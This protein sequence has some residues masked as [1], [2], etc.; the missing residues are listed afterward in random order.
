MHTTLLKKMLFIAL[1]VMGSQTMLAD[2]FETATEAVANMRVG[3]NLGNTLDS[4]SGDVN[5]MW[6]EKWSQR[7]PKDY[8]TAW[9]QPVTKPELMKLF[10]A[11]GFNAIR[12]PVT[13]YPHMEAKFLL[14]G[15]VWDM[16]NDDIGTKIQAAWMKRVHEVVDYVISQDM[17]C[18]LNIHHDTGASSTAWLIAS[19]ADYAKQKERYEEVWRQIAEEFKDYD[20]HL[21]FEGYNEMLDTYDS[22]CFA[23]FA[24]PNNYNSSVATSA[25]NA[26]NSYA[27]SFVD[28]V[29]AT[30]GNNAQ[31]NL[32]VSTYSASSGSGTWSSHLQDPLKKLKLPADNVKDH[33]IFEVHSYIDVK[34]LSSAKSEVK[35]T[36]S[37][38]KT[39]LKGAPVI[40]GEW[41]TS[42][43]NGYANY[44]SNMLAFAR[45]FVEQAKANNMG[46]FYWMGLSDGQHRS[47][48]EF[49]EADLKDAII[50]GY[51]GDEGY[52]GITH[53]EASP[54]QPDVY[55][56]LS[57]HRLPAPQR[58]LNIIREADGTVRKVYR[59]P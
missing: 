48:P 10:K 25:Y 29:R 57:G 15:T 52:Q 43:E 28:A 44:H 34:S 49:N 54:S 31:R 18:I 39:N 19:E 38:L 17:Y 24:A 32:I 42:T 6:I 13:W 33:L 35:Q 26:I 41:G 11:A 30:G 27:Q 40:F 23:S 7:T 46:T 51:Y 3:W 5:N 45:Y 56:S 2:D 8:E 22:W 50:K 12:V 36:I 9:G 47:V 20:E 4:N 53:I 58:G 16:A 1:M 37:A 55:Y 14:T 59:N 21:L